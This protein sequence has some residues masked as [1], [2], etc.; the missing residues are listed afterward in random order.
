MG[1]EICETQTL[2]IMAGLGRSY[3]MVRTVFLPVCPK[4]DKH[5]KIKW[6]NYALYTWY[7]RTSGTDILYGCVWRIQTGSPCSCFCRFFNAFMLGTFWNFCRKEDIFLYF[8]GRHIFFNRKRSRK[9]FCTRKALLR[10]GYGFKFSWLH[11]RR[12]TY[13][14]FS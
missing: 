12:R 14:Y 5:N 7:I 8:H 1:D 13:I 11:T 3:Y 4:A 9:T 6:F 10:G 2:E